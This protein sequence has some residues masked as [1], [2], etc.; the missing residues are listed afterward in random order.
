MGN[1]VLVEIKRSS[2]VKNR[3]DIRIGDICG[4]ING[5]N[6]TLTDVLD[7]IKQNVKELP[8]EVKK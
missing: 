7:M 6:V 4:S 8:L 3:Y 5:S 1:S 2:Y